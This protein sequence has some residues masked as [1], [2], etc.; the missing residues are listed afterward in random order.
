MLEKLRKLKALICGKVCRRAETVNVVT[1]PSRPW[2]VL[3]QEKLLADENASFS[4]KLEFDAFP[5]TH[6]AYGTFFAAL[7]AKA[8]GLDRISVYEFGVGWGGGLME[9][10]RVAVMVEQE[11]GVSIDVYGFD[12]GAGMPESVGFQDLPNVWK[13]GFFHLDVD[14]LEK[15]LTKA[16]LILGNV[17][18]TIKDFIENEK[19]APVGFVS[20][21]VDYYSSTVDVLR[22]FDASEIFLL[23]RIYCYLD[24]VIGDD[25]EIH[26]EYVGEL[27]AIK[28][29]NEQHEH[30]KISK[31]NAFRCKR[32]IYAPWNEQMYVM[33]TFDHSLYCKYINPKPNWEEFKFGVA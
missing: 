19:P 28:E 22:L 24:D 2:P 7:Q 8:L 29:F 16:K 11:T 14:A 12:T 23:P 17:K 9:L 26:C 32:Q 31:I 33:H 3:M 1:P 5:R 25:W 15:K 10:E 4:E 21:D 6:F 27:L 20:F 18:E 30:R 13:P